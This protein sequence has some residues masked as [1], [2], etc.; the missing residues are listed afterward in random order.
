MLGNYASL[1]E[2]VL[3]DA[4]ASF[5]KVRRNQK[6]EIQYVIMGSAEVVM[7]LSPV[8]MSA[9]KTQLYSANHIV[10]PNEHGGW[11]A[12]SATERSSPGLT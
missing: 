5:G 2:G 3:P 10:W 9:N 4:T 6:S 12:R 11:E 1:I 8:F 7:V